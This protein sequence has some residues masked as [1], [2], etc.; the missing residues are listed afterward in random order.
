MEGGRRSSPLT[1]LLAKNAKLAR[2]A[3]KPI[4]TLE[5][6]AIIAGFA[7]FA[8]RCPQWLSM[9]SLATWNAAFAVGTP[10]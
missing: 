8:I 4:E 10:A 7:V 3:K 9:I 5:F 6:F 1:R 2:A